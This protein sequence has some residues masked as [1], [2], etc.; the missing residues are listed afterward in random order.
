MSHQYPA[1]D[2]GREFQAE[3]RKNT[4]LAVEGAHLTQLLGWKEQSR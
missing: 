4:L 1:K 2:I 3:V